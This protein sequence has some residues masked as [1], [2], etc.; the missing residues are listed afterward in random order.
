MFLTI[1]C[2]IFVCQKISKLQ[3][4]SLTVCV[5]LEAVADSALLPAI[6]SA[7]AVVTM[8][9]A[10]VRTVAVI[11]VCLLKIFGPCDDV[12]YRVVDR[13][14]LAIE[15]C[16]CVLWSGSFDGLFFD[17]CGLLAFWPRRFRMWLNIALGC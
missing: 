11:A 10:A 5:T 1:S 12:Q 9:A 6:D 14:G 16:H 4:R 7:G 3:M 8:G 15:L 17:L 2:I 13:R